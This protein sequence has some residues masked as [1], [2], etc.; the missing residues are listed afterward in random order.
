VRYIFNTNYQQ[1]YKTEKRALSFPIGFAITLLFLFLPYSCSRNKTVAEEITETIFVTKKDVYLY[2]DIIEKTIIDEIPAFVKIKTFEKKTLIID[3]DNDKIYYKTDFNNGSGWVESIYLA[4]ID[5]DKKANKKS[6]SITQSVEKNPDIVVTSKT[7]NKLLIKTPE[8]KNNQN[9]FIQIA[10]FKN[11][12]NAKKLLKKIQTQKIPLRIEKTGSSTLI[13]YRLV[14]DIYQDRPTVN[15]SLESI[16]TKYPSLSPIIITN[17]SNNKLKRKQSSNNS[18]KGKTEYYTIQISSFKNKE[19]A[20]KLTKRMTEDG[21]KSKVT[22]AWV[23]GETWFRVQHGE[24]KMKAVA[25]Q[26]ST[27]IKNAYKFNPWISNIYK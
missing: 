3:G 22:E 16:K 6:F 20:L 13:Y 8:N 17:T 12:A 11:H 10:S 26:V 7:D 5:Q 24:Y 18:R 25:K 1:V 14:S 19:A 27:K 21:Y 2:S 15:N 9:Y 4:I 23:K